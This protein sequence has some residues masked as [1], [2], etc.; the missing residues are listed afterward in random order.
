MVVKPLW[1]IRRFQIP[2]LC[3]FPLALNAPPDSEGLCLGRSLHSV[4]WV[5]NAA[6]ASDQLRSQLS[7][8]EG[9]WYPQSSSLKFLSL[10]MA[11]IIY[12]LCRVMRCIHGPPQFGRKNPPLI[13]SRTNVWYQPPKPTLSIFGRNP[14]LGQDESKFCSGEGMFEQQQ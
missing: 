5:L 11:F 13:L 10:P 9:W 3:R 2:N 7:S 1:L 12:P 4:Q 8:Q 6:A 14:A